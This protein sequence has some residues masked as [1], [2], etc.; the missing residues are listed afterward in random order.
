MQYL[1]SDRSISFSSQARYAQL[2]GLGGVTLSAI[3]MDDIDGACGQG[4]YPLL[5]AV[6]NV[7]YANETD[8][9][10]IAR[11]CLISNNLHGCI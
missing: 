7:F 5:H 1:S 8:R 4:A 10:G 9:K 3:L 11:R 6:A 2:Q